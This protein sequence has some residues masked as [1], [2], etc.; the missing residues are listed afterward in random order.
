M[1]QNDTNWHESSQNDTWTTWQRKT[2]KPSNLQK[3]QRQKIF[4]GFLFPHVKENLL[5]ETIKWFD[6][7]K[8]F[9]LL[10]QDF[11]IKR[12]NVYRKDAILMRNCAIKLLHCGFLEHWNSQKS[13][14][15]IWQRFSC[16]LDESIEKKWK[17][18]FFS[19]WPF[20]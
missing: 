5:K 19:R 11:W 8:S 12:T 20:F 18:N 9:F 13:L 3:D 6:L 15:N 14:C 7:Q 17:K 16:L 1:S 10:E 2:Q 4:L